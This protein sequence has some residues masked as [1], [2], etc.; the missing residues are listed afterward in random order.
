MILVCS[1]GTYAPI[2]AHVNVTRSNGRKNSVCSF[3]LNLGTCQA[4]RSSNERYK[5]TCGAET[6]TNTT[7][8]KNYTVTIR[9]VDVVDDALWVCAAS[10]Q[11]VSNT[12][13]INVNG[14]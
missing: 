10:E 5:C 11:A 2:N 9:S 4:T 12:L 7:R 13:K 1:M 6:T 3:K 14:K 8:I